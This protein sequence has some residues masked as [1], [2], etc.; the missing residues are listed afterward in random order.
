MKTS[1]LLSVI[2]ILTGCVIGTSNEIKTAEKILK[3]F[4]CSNIETTQLTHSSMTSYHEHSLAVSK[5][6]ATSYIESYKSGDELFKIPLNEVVQQ[7][8]D[9]YKSACESLGGVQQTQSE[10]NPLH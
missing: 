4:K 7:Q 1:I 10:T 8:Y 3:Q 6:K 9:V 2:F 5:E